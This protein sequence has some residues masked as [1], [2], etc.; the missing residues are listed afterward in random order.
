M[1]L[2]SS[3]VG[4]LYLVDPP[5]NQILKYVA[6]S[7]GVWSS[8]VTY[9]AP[10]VSVD[11]TSAIDI[12]IDSDVW[13][14]RGDGAIWRFSAGKLADFTLRDLD[15][16]LSKPSAIFTTQQLAMIYVADAGNQRIVQFDKV[17]S[18]FVRQFKPHGQER[19]AFNALKSIA[20]DEANKKIFFINGN[21][22]YLATIPQ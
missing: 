17:T 14:L 3:Y 11:M 5:R 16:P 13:V 19:D 10:G 9:F 4:N 2:A 18:K 12:A 8:S 21:Q 15:T 1:N 22:A 6:A 20:V 7:E